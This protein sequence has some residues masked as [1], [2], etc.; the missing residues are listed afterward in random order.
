MIKEAI[1][2][3]PNSNMAYAYD[4]D[5]LHIYLQTGRDD[6]DRVEML[7]GDPHDYVPVNGEYFW[8]IETKPRI[9]LTKKYNTELFDYWFSEEIVPYKRAKYAFLLYKGND[10]YFYG[11]KKL[12]KVDLE[13]DKKIIY[14]NFEYFNYPYM[15]EEDIVKP[16]EWC[17]STIWYQIFPERFAHSEKRKGEY[18]PWGSVEKGIDNHMFFGGNI[19]GIIEKIPYLRN[20][21]INGI[22]FTPMF[23]ATSAHKYD[24][25]DYFKIDPS[26]GTNKDL[27]EMVE[28]C[29]HA[30]IKVMLDAVFNHCGWFHP[31]FQDVVKKGKK[32]KYYDCFYIEDDNIINFPLK[33]NKPIYEGRIYPNYRTFAFT[34][35]MPKLKTSNPIIEKYLLK[36]ATYWI[37][38]YDIDGWRLDVSNEVSHAFWRKFKQA[39]VKVK[40]DIYILGENW[41]DSNPWLGNDQFNAVMNYEIAYPIW[42]FF[43]FKEV[44]K[45][46]A[47]E[48]TYKINELLVRYPRNVAINMF[49]LI[50]SHDTMR[51]LYRANGNKDIVKL[52]YLFIFSFC[53]SPAIYYGDEIGLDG[54][55]DPDNR[56]CMIWNEEKQDIDLLDFFKN[57][58]ILRKTYNAFKTVDITWLHANNNVLIY[59]KDNLVFIINNN[60]DEVTITLPESLKKATVTD[61]FEEKNINLSLEINIKKYGYYIF[62]I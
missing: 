18:L 43:T 10:T 56:R 52:A 51:I 33:D 1:R 24:T 19:Q 35:F 3:T 17:Q 45:I 15:N 30:G 14:D 28:K 9:T 59:Q 8:V 16:L 47:Q 7:Y 40:P 6:I 60:D 44:N 27:K 55:K 20:L 11:S 61:L 48:F 58:I 22:Y 25:I 53:G 21:G 32:S 5:H 39:V 12:I 62:M 49:N 13:R 2:H 42:Q 41:E 50:D 57:L 36:V 31:F 34:P 23:A 46:T 38:E 29:H 4:N 26:F 54:G 37:K